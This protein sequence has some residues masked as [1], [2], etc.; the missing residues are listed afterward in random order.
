MVF[1]SKLF[2]V[3]FVCLENKFLLPVSEFEFKWHRLERACL[4][5]WVA[6]CKPTPEEAAV[7]EK[8]STDC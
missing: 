8:V 7:R 1:N 2:H 6:G 5:E 3:M 4:Q